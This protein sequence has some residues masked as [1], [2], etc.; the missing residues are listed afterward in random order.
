MIWWC[1]QI[2]SAVT[3]SSEF[4]WSSCIPGYPWYPGATG[5]LYRQS[6]RI[7]Q[8]FLVFAILSRQASL[9]HASRIGIILL[10]SLRSRRCVGGF[11]R[12]RICS[13]RWRTCRDRDGQVH[14]RWQSDFCYRSCYSSFCSCILFAIVL[15]QLIEL[16]FLAQQA[17]LKWLTL[18]R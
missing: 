14:C 18:H 4:L 12:N 13:T 8:G 2:L 9:S 17:E 11:W 15:G 7:I 5:F 10:P 3:E 16:E 1:G 6:I